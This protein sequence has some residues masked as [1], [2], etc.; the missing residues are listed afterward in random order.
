MEQYNSLDNLNLKS[1][2]LS[3]GSFDGV[4]LGHHQILNK[5][6]DLSRK[7]DLES[8]IITFDPIPYVYINNIKDPYNLF[9]NTE[10]KDQISKFGINYLITLTFDDNLASQNPESFF[11]KYLGNIGINYLVI[12]YD[13]KLGKNKSGTLPVLQNIGR[14]NG[15]EVIIIPPLKVDN[16]IVSSSLIRETLKTGHI[17]KVNEYL[18]RAYSIRGMIE[19]GDQRGQK[20][21]FPTANLNYC[22]NRLLPKN[23]VYATISN[24]NDKK[25]FSVTNIGFKPTFNDYIISQ[26]IET[27]ILNFNN[28]IYKKN[29]TIEFFDKIRDEI[30]FKNADELKLQISKDILYTKKVLANVNQTSSLLT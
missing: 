6:N 12:G 4:H 13:F 9:S 24:I 7:H 20:I 3:I 29:I 30:K 17:K 15:F 8:I 11:R 21:G 19:F 1:T 27:H 5:V 2:V 14:N 23:G 25:Y 16:Q 22:K 26:S 28:N 10:K 18:G